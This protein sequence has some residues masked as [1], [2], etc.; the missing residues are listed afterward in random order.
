MKVAVVGVTGMVGQVMLKVLMEMGLPVTTLIPVASSKSKGSKIQ[1]NGAEYPVVEMHEALKENPDIAIFSAGGSVSLEW[2]PKFAEQGTYVID[3]SSAWRMD[4]SKKLI[5]PEVNGQTLT[6]SDTIIPNPNCS[7]I[8][9]VLVLKPLHDKYRVKRVVMSTYQSITGTG[10]KAVKQM[11]NERVG[12]ESDMAYSYPIDKNCIPQCDV[13]LEN[14]YTK[15]EMKLT[16]ETK[17]ILDPTINVSA[18]A[19]RVP[20]VGGHSEAVNVEFEHEFKL[21]E[22][23]EVLSAMPGIVVMDDPSKQVYP[24][25]IHAEG[26]NEVFVGRIRRDES[27]P[28]TVNLWI[29][30]DNLRKGAAT[31]A[32]QIA[33]IIAAFI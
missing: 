20:V 10:V 5:V 3:N 29:V 15:E 8:Q 19:V 12:I 21:E 33:K 22:L 17:K 26:K 18:T 23:R 11:N 27:Q 30:T 7:T 16:N 13:F 24:M 28:R 4:P 31:N 6:K 9:L 32:V 14:D 25:P 2:A 1:F